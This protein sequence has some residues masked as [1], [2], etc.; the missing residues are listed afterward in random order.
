MSTN[1]YKLFN[2]ERVEITDEENTQRLADASKQ[3]ANIKARAWLDG[4]LAEYG[5]IGDQLDEIFHDFDIW[6]A[7]I[8]SV[9]DKY[10]K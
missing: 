8:Q 2:G 4:R 1:L 5:S 10:P 3:I 6:K 9:K 7:R